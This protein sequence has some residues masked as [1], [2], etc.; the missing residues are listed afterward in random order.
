MAST[1]LAEIYSFQIKVRGKGMRDPWRCRD[2]RNCIREA[3]GM[4]P[5]QI[6]ER[7]AELQKDATK[8]GIDLPIEAQGTDF[9][10]LAAYVRQLETVVKATTQWM[11]EEGIVGI[12]VEQKP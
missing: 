11:N 6:L 3:I 2:I 4:T 5:L 7:L 12:T 1:L 8:A 10:A 9:A